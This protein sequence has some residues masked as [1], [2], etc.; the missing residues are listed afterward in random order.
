MVLG[1]LHP[2]IRAELLE[3]GGKIWLSVPGVICLKLEAQ[4]MCE[5]IH[6]HAGV[7]LCTNPCAL[8]RKQAPC[9]CEICTPKLPS[10]H[11]KSCP[12]PHGAQGIGPMALHPG[13]I[14]CSAPIIRIYCTKPQKANKTK[15]LL[16]GLFHHSV[17]HSADDEFTLDS[18]G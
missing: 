2:Q 8:P 14:S 6:S 9:S 16:N 12:P 11:G 13:I 18:T 5:Q 10:V 4:R 15:A 17:F 3:Q 7:L 1:A